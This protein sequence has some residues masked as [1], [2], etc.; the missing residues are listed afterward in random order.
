VVTDFDDPARLRVLA[1]WLDALERPDFSVGEWD[2]G[3]RD[4]R[5]VIQM[6][7]VERSDEAQRFVSDV[8]G[9]GWVYPFDWAAWAATPAARAL[10][11][12]PARVAAAQPDDLA[13]L[14][15][16]I[17]RG[18]RFSEGTLLHAHESGLLAAIA[19]RASALLE[20]DRD[21]RP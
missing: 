14:L 8:A 1:G 11:A 18:D 3:R 19:R 20:A 9:A 6:P 12:E 17:V 16:T 4:A 5:G 2:G 10:L 21:D 13:R 15:T 7:Y